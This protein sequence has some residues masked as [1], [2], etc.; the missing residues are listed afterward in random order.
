[1]TIYK[2]ISVSKILSIMEKTKDEELIYQIVKNNINKN[3][4]ISKFIRM[5]R[6]LK[7]KKEKEQL[8]DELIFKMKRALYRIKNGLSTFF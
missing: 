8:E 6:T 3:F 2:Y 5:Y 1:M 7:S 4:E